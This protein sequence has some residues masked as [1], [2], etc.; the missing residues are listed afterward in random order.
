M[1]LQPQ[2]F[3]STR[4]SLLSRLRNWDDRESW[5]KFF[6]TY[7]NL[8]YRTAIW[9]GL[10]EW[11]AQEVLQETLIVAAKK[12]PKFQYDSSIGSFRGWL[13]RTT[14]WRIEDQF[15]KRRLVARRWPER[16]SET[17]R[18]GTVARIP[19]PRTG[20]LEAG[21]NRE[22]KQNLL[23]AALERVK[24]SVSANQYQIFD[25]Y[26][27]KHWPAGKVAETLG[28]S[29]GQVFLAKH[30]VLPLLKRE[31]HRLEENVC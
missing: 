21:W 19:D 1:A 2:R 10:N 31:V 4:R 23:E 5:E 14:R 18:T 24:R 11:E 12:L 30:R 15:R 27:I 7:S 29:A 8:I 25:L 6:D 17:D 3:L 28:I 9:A 22:W 20:E 16:K 26:V 13:L